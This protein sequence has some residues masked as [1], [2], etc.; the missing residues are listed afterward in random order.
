MLRDLSSGLCIATFEVTFE[1]LLCSS[2]L[3]TGLGSS[4][5]TQL[6][7]LVFSFVHYHRSFDSFSLA[8]LSSQKRK[9]QRWHQLHFKHS[10]MPTLPSLLS[11]SSPSHPQKRSIHTLPSRLSKFISPSYFATLT[12]RLPGECPSSTSAQARTYLYQSIAGLYSS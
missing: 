9:R 8:L 7:A 6:S 10:K 1:D 2:R 5:S 3:L 11:V 4:W 12:I